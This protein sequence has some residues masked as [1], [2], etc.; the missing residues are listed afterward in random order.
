MAEFR[1]TNEHRLSEVGKV[2][3]VLKRPR[4][5]I[6]TNDDYPAHGQWLEKTEAEIAAGTKRAM[7]SYYNNEAVAAIV[8][9]RHE[10]QNNVV[11]IRNISVV[12]EARGRLIGSFAL[13][14]TELEAVRHDF[15]DTETI[16]VDTKIS[17]AEMIGFLENH[18]YSVQEIA[19]LYDQSTGPDAILAKHMP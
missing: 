6:P 17:N 19:N 13:V 4:L 1:F 10:T 8:Y 12:P 14:N 3:D 7:I 16:T 15:P 11:E 2:I 9:R 18:G 5:W